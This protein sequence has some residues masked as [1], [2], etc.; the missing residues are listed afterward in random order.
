MKYTG[1]NL[2]NIFP[3]LN[4]CR[5]LNFSIEDDNCPWAAY[6]NLYGHIIRDPWVIKKSY[7]ISS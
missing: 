1:N 2:S 4:I 6:T 3:V 5:S 7:A